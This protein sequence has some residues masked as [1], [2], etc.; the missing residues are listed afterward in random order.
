[1]TF[2]ENSD[3]LLRLQALRDLEILDTP[4]EVEFDELVSLAAAICNTP[5]SAVSLVD[6]DRQWFKASIGLDVQET[7]RDV[8]FC[9]H[10][11][12]QSEMFVVENA[13]QDERFKHNPLVTGNPHIRFY[14]GVPLETPAGFPVGALCVIDRQPRSLTDDQKAALE[15]LA[16]QVK[17]RMELRMQRR[18]LERALEENKELNQ[19]LL[20]AN[21]K[22]QKLATTDVLTGIANRRF[23]QERVAIEFS[24]ARRH[25]RPLSLVM[26][27]VDDFKK[28]ND[29]YGHAAG[30][31]VLRGIGQILANSAR[32]ADLPGRVGGEE[33]AILLTETDHAG[34]TAYAERLQ[35]A[36]RNARFDSGP[37]TASMGVATCSDQMADWERLVMQADHAMYRAK[38]MGRDRFVTDGDDATERSQSTAINGPATS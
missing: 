26:L 6:R 32:K 33:F 2:Q 25:K 24:N 16:R 31:E 35:S 3:E 9:A 22:L 14:A 36:I 27:D 34:A 17:A 18:A 37:I 30:D 28:R 21:A 23:F 1:M 11:I 4:T 5:I 8:S 15:I 19:E 13:E 10:A 38:R 12:R 7:H 29:T 20:E